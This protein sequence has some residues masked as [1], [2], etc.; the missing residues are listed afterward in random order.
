MLEY[1]AAYYKTED[2]WY[3]VKVL[4]FPGAV[5][6][7]RTLNSAKGMIRDALRLLAES[8]AED[9]QP[10]PKPDP[11]A[12]DTKADFSETI[13]LRIRATCGGKP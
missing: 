6:Q 3:V 9:G 8:L 5:S 4:D 2:G 11:G 13:P 10:L 1:H 12:A 7:G